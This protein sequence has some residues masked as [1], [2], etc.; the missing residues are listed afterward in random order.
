MVVYARTMTTEDDDKRKGGIAEFHVGF[1]STSVAG[2]EGSHETGRRSFRIV[3]LAELSAREEFSLSSN[4]S[5]P[6][7]FERATF[8]DAMARLGPSFAIDVPHPNAPQGKP[9]RVELRLDAMRAFRPDTLAKRVAWLRSLQE[10]PKGVSFASR[11]SETGTLLD[12]ILDATSGVTPTTTGP[13]AR[14]ALSAALT[15]IVMHP[16][17]RR[18]ERTWRGL[19]L[20]VDRCELDSGIV[21]E[22][23]SVSA[24]Q[25]DAT[26]E[27]LMGGADPIDLLVIDHAL[28]STRRDLDRLEAWA[29]RAEALCT[30]M[31]VGARPEVLGFDDLAAL[32]R[33]QRRVRSSD[34][35][36]AMALRNVAKRESMRLVVL[37]MN[38]VV[39]RPRYEGP[40]AHVE[41]ATLDEP[42]DVVVNPAYLVAILAAASFVRTGWA[43]A[44]T[45]PAHGTVGALPVHML[46]DRGTQV[47]TPLEALVTEQAA[48]EA[49]SAGV[50]VFASVENRDVAILADAP[51]VHRTADAVPALRLGDQLFVTRVARL[52]MQIA[53]AIPQGTDEQAAR[54][55][56]R[57]SLAEVFGSSPNT[58][59]ISVAMARSGA[60]MEV[61]L[62]P[63][64]FQGVRID[65]VTFGAALA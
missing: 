61:T 31:V 50:A 59:E 36:R 16:E 40:V 49:A 26:L 29:V 34:D 57:I 19:K 39:G 44:L 18:L 64:G 25:V 17:V 8:D 56:V 47:A 55:V 24:E 46:D 1:G 13:A 28:G 51:M 20:L 58:P 11:P 60:A 9:M 42:G 53:A 65:E 22:A 48:R 37:V 35:P 7:R 52:V 41:G 27:R 3:V 33:T 38:G 54:D 2:V 23:L 5:E 15:S 63:R 30:P 21:V 43:C 6:V 62:R 32:G 45:G 14:G 4:W 10:G 12:E